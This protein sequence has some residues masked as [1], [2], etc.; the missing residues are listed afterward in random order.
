MLTDAA[1]SANLDAQSCRFATEIGEPGDLL[2]NQ[3]HTDDV[4]ACR[5][6]WG[7]FGA[8]RD[9]CARRHVAGEWMPPPVEIDERPGA[10]IAIEMCAHA[11]PAAARGVAAQPRCI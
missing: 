11:G 2:D 3:V 8:Q 7:P 5:T 6:K 10:I 1:I 9:R 4:G